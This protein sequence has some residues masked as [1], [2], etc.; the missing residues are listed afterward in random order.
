M[1]YTREEQIK[2]ANA[3]EH[4]ASIRGNVNEANKQLESVLFLL[5]DAKERFA[6]ANSLAIEKA[7]EAQAFEDRSD[8]LERRSIF[9]KGETE[10]LENDKKEFS[11]YVEKTS[12]ELEKKQSQIRI[13]EAKHKDILDEVTALDAELVKLIETIKI[14]K[15]ELTDIENDKKTAETN[16]S[17]MESAYLLKVEQY[18]KE[19]FQM[20]EKLESLTK[21]K[22]NLMQEINDA[23]AEV[24]EDRK[25]LREEQENFNIL[26]LRFTEIWQEAHPGQELKL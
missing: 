8:E 25:A 21:R 4:L 24:E 13:A 6:I 23:R 14:A 5:A 7:I 10:K 17:N 2:I 9:I 20:E 19:I 3:S 22:E 18:N 15:S 12:V 26:V 11:D 1:D 16:V